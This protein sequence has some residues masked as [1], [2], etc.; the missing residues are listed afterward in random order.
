M[1]LCLGDAILQLF[2]QMFIGKK[3]IIIFNFTFT[4]QNKNHLS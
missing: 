3:S 2:F 1:G 4:I